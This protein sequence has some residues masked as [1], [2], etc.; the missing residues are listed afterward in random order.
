VDTKWYCFDDSACTALVDNTSNSVLNTGFNQ[1]CTENAYILFYKRRHCMTNE[2]WWINHVDR[3]LY[4]SQEF[5][6]YYHAFSE[7]ERRQQLM[8]AESA[9]QRQAN[10]NGGGKKPSS[11][12]RSSIK[13]K[14]L[15]AS[16]S[17]TQL[18]YVS[19]N[20]GELLAMTN[21]GDAERGSPSEF[22]YQRELNRQI[23]RQQLQQ[24]QQQNLINLDDQNYI[25]QINN[26]QINFYDEM[27]RP[28]RLLAHQ[29]HQQQHQ[30]IPNSS[31]SRSTG[32]GPMINGN[33]TTATHHATPSKPSHHTYLTNEADVATLQKVLGMDTSG[34][35]P[36][37][38][39]S[40][41]DTTNN[42]DSNLMQFTNGFH[43]Q[44]TLNGGGGG[45]TGGGEDLL[46]NYP[47]DNEYVYNKQRVMEQFNNNYTG[48]RV[49]GM[50][51]PSTHPTIFS[52]QL[53]PT[54]PYAL[55]QQSQRP[56]NVQSMYNTNSQGGSA[57]PPV[58]DT[59][60]FYHNGSSG[61]G[62]AKSRY[63]NPR[64]ETNI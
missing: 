64:I 16:K 9:Q 12:L 24:Q 4:N 26:G 7:I 50:A 33:T 60:A 10:S 8:L 29:Y 43:R 3:A 5:V 36:S 22:M 1:V 11:G 15:G 58:S 53:P 39:S 14:L 48:Q 45:D 55:Q 47:S 40:S 38:L 49:A 25:S 17:G 23:E 6:D 28:K 54:P 61:S 19:G 30:H 18:N 59:N 27:N 57:T 32:V 13:S 20:G 46:L 41:S 56:F 2:T 44:M 35:T 31:L 42:S 21:G 37:S 51:Q 52:R 63:G 62:N 34:Q